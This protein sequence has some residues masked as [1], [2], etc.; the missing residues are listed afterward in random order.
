MTRKKH[1]RNPSK[2]EFKHL[3]Q[4]IWKEVANAC[5]NNF[6]IKDEPD[7]LDENGAI[8]EKENPF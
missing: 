3:A 8:T 2:M 5:N 7:K 1:E 6:G 4:V